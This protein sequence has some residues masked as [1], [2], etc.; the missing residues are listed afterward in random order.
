MMYPKAPTYGPKIRE[1]MEQREVQKS[2]A[3]I[4]IEKG[5]A[6]LQQEPAYRSRDCNP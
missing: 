2:A 5:K 4:A 6:D 1:R 3:Q